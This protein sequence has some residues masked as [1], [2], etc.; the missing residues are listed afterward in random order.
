MKEFNINNGQYIKNFMGYEI[1]F[2]H[3][4]YS[5]PALGLR[6]IAWESQMER[7][8]KKELKKRENK[9]NEN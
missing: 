5:C 9:L 1:Y 3:I 6:G 2:L 7:A 4:S 8:I